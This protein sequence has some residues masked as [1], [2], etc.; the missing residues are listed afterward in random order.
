MSVCLL[1]RSYAHERSTNKITVYCFRRRRVSNFLITDYLHYSIDTPLINPNC[2]RRAVLLRYLSR[3][4]FKYPYKNLFTALRA[5]MGLYS[6]G[7]GISG[8]FLFRQIS[9]PMRWVFAYSVCQ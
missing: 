7:A 3:L 5:T 6:F 2:S 8:Y 4:S 9:L 1:T